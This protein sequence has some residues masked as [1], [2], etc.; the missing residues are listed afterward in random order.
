MIEENLEQMGS[1]LFLSRGKTF[2]SSIGISDSATAM[3]NTF[4]RELLK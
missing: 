2:D 1:N 4:I 3:T